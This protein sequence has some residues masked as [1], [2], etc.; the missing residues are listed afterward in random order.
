[1]WHLYT[2]AKL[3]L[4]LSS[5]LKLKQRPSLV[6]GRDTLGKI[7]AL[8]TERVPGTEAAFLAS[9]ITAIVLSPLKIGSRAWPLSDVDCNE[10]DATQDDTFTRNR[11][12]VSFVHFL[13]YLGI[14][15]VIAYNELLVCRGRCSE[16]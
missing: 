14:T 11:P 2:P 5:N 4:K 3:S 10:S 16:R 6:R 13:E 8:S 7:Q 12:M 1:M 9:A 15:R